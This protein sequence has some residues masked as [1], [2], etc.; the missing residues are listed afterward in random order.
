MSVRHPVG[1]VFVWKGG[2]MQQDSMVVLTTA[3]A[4]GLEAGAYGPAYQGGRFSACAGI[5]T[6]AMNPCLTCEVAAACRTERRAAHLLV[7]RK[8]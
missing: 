5:A 8:E 2:P 6:G 3:I 7:Q 4:T 1:F